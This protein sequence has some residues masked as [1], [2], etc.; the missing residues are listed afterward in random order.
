MTIAMTRRLN[1]HK[2]PKDLD[3]QKARSKYWLVR[4]D[5]TRAFIHDAA[6]FT[7]RISAELYSLDIFVSAM[8]LNRT[9]SLCLELSSFDECR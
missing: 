5:F 6:C 8:K 1:S 2:Q 9:D 3:E 7:S 4:K